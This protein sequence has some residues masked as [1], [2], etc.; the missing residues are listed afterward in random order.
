EGQYMASPGKRAVKVQEKDG[1]ILWKYDMMHELG[2]YRHNGSCCAVSSAG[3]NI[4]ACTSNG[5]DWTH[6]NIPSPQ[7]PSLI[8]LN[9][10]TGELAGQDD[11]GIGPRIKHSQW[12]SPSVGEINGK[13][14]V[15][16]GG[17]DG[18][19]Y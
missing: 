8:A 17:G 9:K 5:Q 13:K 11:A 6:V 2:V 3:E 12:S 14:Q 16:F 1:D 4:Y 18:V 19:L 15:Y 7:S 10:T